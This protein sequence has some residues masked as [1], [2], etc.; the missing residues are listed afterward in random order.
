MGDS[1]KSRDYS[2]T[3]STDPVS[4]RHSDWYM[5]P[6]P[7]RRM[8]QLMRRNNAVVLRNYTIW[9]ASLAA[10]GVLAYLSI[11]S[12]YAVPAF[13][14]YG[15]LYG[16]CAE[17]R[18]HE[19][20]HGTPFRTK[21]VNESF[22]IV[23]GFMSFKNPYLW[24]WSHA[25]HHTD[26]I[27]VGRDPEIAYPRPPDVWGMFLNV[28]HLKAGLNEL[29]RTFRLCF[30]KLSDDE[31]QYVPE[32]ERPKIFLH[33]RL[34]TGSLMALALMSISMGS[35]LPLLFAGLPTFYG[36][37]VH[38]AL[39][40]TQHAGLAEDIPDHRLNT[41]TIYL[42]PVLSFI[43]S[44]MNYHVEHHMF[45]MVPFYALPDLHEEIKADCPPA[46]SGM[47]AAY[48]EMIPAL[49]RQLRE[50]CYFVRRQLPPHAGKPHPDAM[51]FNATP[52]MA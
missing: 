40:A 38:S 18:F 6:V 50:P 47:I 42:G 30:A 20:L 52:A 14:L 37:W 41:R 33:A 19:C 12:W 22:L 35:L 16:S 5:C 9:T 23:L 51:A 28:L 31:A 15:V 1:P 29:G 48:R 10:A 45:P 24:R 21:A 43:Y 25:R 34:Q 36:S 4:Y 7:R 2:L 17:S 39:A 32:S 46:Y 11:G 8:K 26:T 3:G 44:N 27:I 49:R 13:L